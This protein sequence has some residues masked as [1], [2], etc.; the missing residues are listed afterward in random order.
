[1]DTQVKRRVDEEWVYLI[2]EAKKIG[3]GIEEIQAFLTSNGDQ[4]MIIK[5]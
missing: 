2:Q 1:M 4:K 3:L 5:P